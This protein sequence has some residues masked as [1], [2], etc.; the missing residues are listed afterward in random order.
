MASRNL[1]LDG[2]RGCLA[3][4]VLVD[5]ACTSVG[6]GVLMTPASI[7]VLLFFAISGCVLTRG[8]DSRFGAF[9]ARRVVRL[10]PVYALCLGAGYWMS[11]IEPSLLQFVWLPI[12]GATTGPAVDP[13]AWSLS[14]EAWAMLAMPL[15]VWVGRAPGI[16]LAIALLAC[17][18]VGEFS[19][20]ALFAACFF[21]GAWL[22]RFELRW[23]PL[24][25]R[26]PQWL[27]RISYPLYICHNPII[28][29][30]GLPLWASVPLALVAA[31]LLSRTVEAWSIEASRR[32]G[33]L[34]LKGKAP[35]QGALQAS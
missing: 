8:W 12:S 32:V 29:F 27:G 10:W 1:T 17:L 33:R 4:L 35:S 19:G 6:N 26:L 15:F 3:A 20:Y 31:D 9:L 16:R 5:H 21:A 24:E 18:I 2:L 28:S 13:P 11:G 30:T 34:T 7:A 25:M 14:V 22:S 23:T